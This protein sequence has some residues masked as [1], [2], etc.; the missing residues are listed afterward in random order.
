MAADAL[1]DGLEEAAD[2]L[3]RGK[4]RR[5]GSLTATSGT[6]EA[7]TL[8]HTKK[9]TAGPIVVQ[10]AK[11]SSR[12][13]TRVTDA[14]EKRLLLFSSEEEL[15]EASAALTE[16]LYALALAHTCIDVELLVFAGPVPEGREGATKFTAHQAVLMSVVPKFQAMLEEAAGSGSSAVVFENTD[17]GAF[18]YVLQ[19]IY[20]GYAVLADNSPAVLVPILELSQRLDMAALGATVLRRLV[21]LVEKDNCVALLAVAERLPGCG[22][23]RDVCLHN[24]RINL[25]SFEPA[26]LKSLSFEALSAVMGSDDVRVSSEAHVMA[27]VFEWLKT[28][29]ARFRLSTASLSLVRYSLL[30]PDDLAQARSK[31]NAQMNTGIVDVQLAGGKAHP[32][33]HIVHPLRCVSTK[34][35]ATESAAFSAS[36]AG[37]FLVVGCG[38]G[39]VH[40]WDTR[41]WTRVHTLLGHKAAVRGAVF[42]GAVL[43]SVSHDR[44]IRGWDSQRWECQTTLFSAHGSEIWAAAEYDAMLITGAKEGEIKLWHEGDGVDIFSGGISSAGLKCKSTLTGH[45]GG[46]VALTTNGASLYSASMDGTCRIWNVM[47]QQ[48]LK[49][50]GDGT[51][52]LTGVVAANNVFAISYLDGT[53]RVWRKAPVAAAAAAAAE[54]G[55]G[56]AAATPGTVCIELA[57]ATQGR[58]VRSLLLVDGVEQGA[59]TIPDQFL[60]TGTT[61][62]MIKT[63]DIA[64]PAGSMPESRLVRTLDTH[65]GSVN[66]LCQLS[67]EFFVSASS[68]SSV[69]VW[70]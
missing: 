54:G 40:V 26:D 44:S 67:S 48:C 29:K 56:A 58:T 55:E 30:S 7:D 62:G 39:A 63:W 47:S 14:Y 60:L 38:S 57:A 33:R 41:T 20:L 15:D 22:A 18:S 32:R 49:S 59:A 52:P 69:V 66:G 12:V 24:I 17:A 16:K 53:V 23:L 3:S 45:R 51:Q 65:R 35:M 42:C 50:I 2:P 9:A 34:S 36:M 4:K 1:F 68:D 46:V 11:S 70:Q 13:R 10:V 64:G 21:R 5:G 27:V 25:D 31:L 43:Y 8:L 61:D 19:F 6:E 37:R 28:D